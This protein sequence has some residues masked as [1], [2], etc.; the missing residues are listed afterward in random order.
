VTDHSLLPL[1][2][3]GFAL[4]CTK[5]ANQSKLCEKALQSEPPIELHASVPQLNG[6]CKSRSS[7]ES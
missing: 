2:A 3:Q 7:S 4:L 6:H 5:V 1:R